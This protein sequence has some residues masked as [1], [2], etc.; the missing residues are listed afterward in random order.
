MA[1][2]CKRALAGAPFQG[3]LHPSTSTDHA[4]PS[5]LPQEGAGGGKS[6]HRLPQEPGQASAISLSIHLLADVVPALV[7]GA[8]LS[9]DP[10]GLCNGTVVKR[11]N[12]FMLS[13]VLCPF[14]VKWT[15]TKTSCGKVGE[16][17]KGISPLREE[18]HGEAA[19]GLNF[20]EICCC[21]KD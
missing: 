11:F 5:S 4:A 13:G 15:Q 14:R 7:Q 19:G 12:F 10:Q 17:T 6:G 3:R 2:S 21:K 18:A 9:W 8:A 16:E 20:G 1:P